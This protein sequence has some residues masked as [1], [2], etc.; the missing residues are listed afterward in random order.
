MTEAWNEV[1]GGYFIPGWHWAA[2]MARRC[3]ALSLPGVQPP[4]TQEVGPVLERDPAG[5]RHRLA[6]LA[7][8]AQRGGVL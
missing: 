5:G 8:R 3:G 7:L 1:R 6:L 4:S 2:A